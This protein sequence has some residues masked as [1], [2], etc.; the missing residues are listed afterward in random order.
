[1]APVDSRCP[2]TLMTSSM[3][4]H[5]EQIAVFVEVSAVAGEVVAGM[6]AQV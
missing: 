1:M 4:P 6:L 2:A 3:R 5:D